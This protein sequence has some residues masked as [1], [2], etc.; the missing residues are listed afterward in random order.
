MQVVELLS[1][2]PSVTCLMSEANCQLIELRKS[3]NHC[4]AAGA[5]TLMPTVTLPADT[6]GTLLGLAEGSMIVS[7]HYSVSGWQVLLSCISTLDQQVKSLLRTV[8]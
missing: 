6:R 1:E 5:I 4:R 3:D 7:W 8:L 2:L